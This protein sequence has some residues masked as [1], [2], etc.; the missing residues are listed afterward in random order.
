VI[1]SV[2]IEHEGPDGTYL[3]IEGRYRTVPGGLVLQVNDDVLEQLDRA[4]EPWRAHRAE[5]ERVRAERAAHVAAGLCGT[6]I[7]GVGPCRLDAGHAGPHSPTDGEV[8]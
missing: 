4:L 5:G 7:S 6:W 2:R 3:V 8:V 1:D